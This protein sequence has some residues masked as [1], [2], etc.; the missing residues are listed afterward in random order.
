VAYIVF[1]V[2]VTF[3]DFIILPL[4]S[5]DFREML[6]PYT[7]WGAS[8]PYIFTIYFSFAF[9]FET[10]RRMANRFS[11]TGLL[12]LVVALNAW[13]FSQSS[14]DDFGNPYLTISPWRPIWTILIPSLWIAVLYS[15]RM[16]RF[17]KPTFESAEA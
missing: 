8:M 14:G 13:R 17:C 1:A 6:V 2:A 16:N 12:I 7:G 15:P 10:K 4:T 9:I 3:A 11:I 5:D